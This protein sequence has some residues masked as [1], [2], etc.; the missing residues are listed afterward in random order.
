[1]DRRLR[2]HHERVD[3]DL[4]PQVT[5][6]KIGSHWSPLHDFS[7]TLFVTSLPIER[8]QPL[9]HFRKPNLI[10]HLFVNFTE[11]F[12]VLSFDLLL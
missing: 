2:V 6:I 7:R 9:G 10:A 11:Q 4:T 3:V 12:I 1:M 5:P 8:G